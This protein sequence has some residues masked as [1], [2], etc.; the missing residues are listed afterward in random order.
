MIFV[1]S[2]G[3]EMITARILQ[4]IL[5]SML[6]AVTNQVEDNENVQWNMPIAKWISFLII[7]FNFLFKFSILMF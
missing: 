1:T 2:L 7:S 6:I 3:V 4:A 5:V